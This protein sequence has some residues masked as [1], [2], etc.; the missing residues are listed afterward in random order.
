MQW[1]FQRKV[2]SNSRGDCARV[3]RAQR[4]VNY[5]AQRHFKA[6]NRETLNLQPFLTNIGVCFKLS[7]CAFKHDAAV[8]HHIHAV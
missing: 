6:H 8:A 2:D 1:A 3:C 7:R 5:R 4:I